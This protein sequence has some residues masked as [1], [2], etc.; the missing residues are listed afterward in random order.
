LTPSEVV[1]LLES[2]DVSQP[3]VERA[4]RILERADVA[5]Y[6]AVTIEAPE[7]LTEL[8]A[9]IHELEGQLR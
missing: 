7:L 6:G 8:E 4:Y 3:T 1:E 2:H 9:I 5:Q